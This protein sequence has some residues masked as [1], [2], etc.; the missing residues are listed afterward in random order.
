M[1]PLKKKETRCS[2]CSLACH[3]GLTQSPLGYLEPDYPEDVPE[4]RRGVCSRGNMTAELLTHVLRLDAAKLAGGEKPRDVPL[5]EA[6]AKLADAA[7]SGNTTLLIDGNLTCEDIA[8][9]LALAAASGGK[10]TAGVYL[11]AED[12]A[13]LDGLAASGAKLLTPEELTECDAI[14]IVGDAL[15]THPVISRP[16]HSLRKA[17][18]RLPLVVIDSLP[19][20]TSIFATH[21]LLARP[22][23]E[24][25]TL[26]AI[27]GE[28]GVKNLG[29]LKLTVREAASESGLSEGALSAAAEVIGEAKKLGVILRAEIGKAA[30]WDQIALLA[31]LIA[32]ARG[33]GVTA[34][35]TYGNA[36]GAYRLMR[37]ADGKL[38]RSGEPGR[39]AIT[40]GTDVVSV[41]SKGDSVTML[42]AIGT[43]AAAASLPVPT[44]GAADI[45]LPLAFNFETGGTTVTGSGEVVTVDA[46]AD[47]P[48][49]AASAGNLVTRLAEAMGISGV[50]RKAETPL[51]EKMPQVDAEAILKRAQPDVPAP[52]EGELLAVTQSD[53]IHF[54]VGSLTGQ[55][56]WAK[57]A[58]AGPVVTV[59]ANDAESLGILN[60]ETVRITSDEGEGTGTVEVVKE[61][62][63][64][65]VAVPGGFA[66]MRRLFPWER[67]TGPV[68]VKIE[69]TGNET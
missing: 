46:V 54:H 1:L 15:A 68:T 43:L 35:L 34:C 3:L 37:A 61:Q 38:D 22:G 30:N 45:V 40:L 67:G 12:Q 11:P 24:S 19:G 2:L 53:A 23:T 29:G 13:A 39:T 50:E 17:N 51:I 32:S 57:Y 25:R 52:A 69:K 64:G 41:F 58:A 18:R 27:A 62:A 8:A 49:E 7:K 9:G 65:V 31:G 10:I 56:A 16:V 4:L 14:L 21:P 42:D 48:G 60:G 66:E 20:K 36:M 44:L 47:A 26:A 5:D 33:G 55:C 6:I 63:A 59:N 28:I